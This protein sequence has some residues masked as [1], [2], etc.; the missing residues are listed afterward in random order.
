MQT[1]GVTVN[2][3]IRPSFVRSLQ[4]LDQTTVTMVEGA[5]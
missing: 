5:A 2:K 3:H 1:L 4:R